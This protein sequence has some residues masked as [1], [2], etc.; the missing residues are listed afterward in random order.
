[1]NE[2]KKDDP[3]KMTAVGQGGGSATS[4]GARATSGST[5]MGQSRPASSQQGGTGGGDQSL[6]D[7]ARPAGSAAANQ[8]QKAGDA[9][10]ET[11]QSAA[12]TAS[13]TA[14]AATET[15]RATAEQVQRRASE[16]YSEASDMARQTYDRAA[17]ATSDAYDYASRRADYVSRRS[18]DQMGRVRHGAERFI[19]E[20][21]VLVGVMGL[22][23]GLIIGALLPRTRHEDRVF[24]RW[25][26]EV[27]DQ[28]MRYARDITQRGREFV[29]ETLGGDDDPRTAKRDSE[30]QRQGSSVRHQNH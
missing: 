24:G 27:R 11:A 7:K 17:S 12:E 13:K 29:E 1:M 3:A 23:A 26:D 19:A 8:A 28:G 18:L 6:T 4:S 25:S 21:P 15:V 14:Q 2:T 20:N 10:R 16:A 9:V 5:G 22:A 30:W